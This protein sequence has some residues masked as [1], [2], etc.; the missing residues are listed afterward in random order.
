M[1]LKKILAQSSNSKNIQDND[2]FISCANKFGIGKNNIHIYEDDINRL[3]FILSED[4]FRLDVAKALE[5]T[6][7][8]EFFYQLSCIDN[9][10]CIDNNNCIAMFKKL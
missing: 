5:Y 10:N 4:N 2:M 8:G 6:F 3:H 7:I 1:D 9:Q